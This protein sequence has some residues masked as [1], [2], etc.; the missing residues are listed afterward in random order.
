MQV[1]LA[2][3]QALQKKMVSALASNP[4]HEEKLGCAARDTAKSSSNRVY[5]GE[6]RLIED[7]SYPS[8]GSP[9]VSNPSTV[10]RAGLGKYI[11][12]P[13]STREFHLFSATNRCCVGSR[14]F[15]IYGATCYAE[16]DRIRTPRE[17]PQQSGTRKK[18][19]IAIEKRVD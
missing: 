16:N 6:S 1:L 9:S 4:F 15:R 2:S 7:Q 11:L 18:L 10:S 19:S 14:Q 5:R 3:T 8:S 17:A 13:N 12:M